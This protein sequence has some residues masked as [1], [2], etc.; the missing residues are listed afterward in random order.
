MRA[1]PLCVSGGGPGESFGSLLVY[2]E[3]PGLAVRV[4]REEIGEARAAWTA[5]MQRWLEGER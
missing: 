3:R 2:F 5:A 4:T 1:S